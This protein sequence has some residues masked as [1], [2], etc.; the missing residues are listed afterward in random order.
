MI[1]PLR[2]VYR[3][4]LM[5]ACALMMTLPMALS[6]EAETAQ[7]SMHTSGWR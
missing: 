6:D 7:E 4:A 1:G 2:S 3:F 5:M